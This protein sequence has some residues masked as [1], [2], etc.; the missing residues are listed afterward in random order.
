MR[1]HSHFTCYCLMS[2]ASTLPGPGGFL[3]PT[4]PSPPPSSTNSVS[5]ASAILPHPRSTPLKPGSSKESSFVDYVDRKLLAVSRRY[6]KRFNTDFEDTDAFDPKS[7]GYEDFGELA[8]DL[9]GV[10]DIV[11]VS[12]TRRETQC[13]DMIHANSDFNISASL[14][15]PYLLT[16]ALTACTNL[17][18]FPFSPRP[19]FHLFN[20]LDM[21]FFSLLRGINAESSE[22]LPGF[23][24]GRAK[25]S[26]TEKVRMRGL[27]E[28]TRVAV[29]EV[30]GAGGSVT[31]A[32]SVTATDDDLTTDGD[33]DD[34]NDAMQGLQ[35]EGNHGRWEMEIARVYEK[36]IVELGLALDSLGTEAPG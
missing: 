1:S 15:T 7:K 33:D 28:R 21:A 30:A 22:R 35:I 26:T 27:V 5:N 3:Q 14:Q 29:V 17:P 11:W 4:L 25:L 23:E 12:A 36:T 9:E 6:E 13:H 2:S 20:K 32:G 24:G 16:I 31:E 10:I 8:Q 34:G 19:T 18:S